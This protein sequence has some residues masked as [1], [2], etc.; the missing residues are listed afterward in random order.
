MFVQIDQSN[1]TSV[2]SFE[3]LKFGIF[4]NC[5]DSTFRICF[6]INRNAKISQIAIKT[7]SNLKNQSNV[8]IRFF[9]QEY[10]VD[11]DV[12]H[13]KLNIRVETSLTNAKKYELIKSSIKSFE[14]FK[15]FKFNIFNNKFKSTFRVCF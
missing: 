10:F 15:K 6:S 7:I 5:F 11:V 3:K 14:L 2:K 8:K 12:T 13:I 1:L 4:I 9:R